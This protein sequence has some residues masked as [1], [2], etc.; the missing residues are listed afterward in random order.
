[1]DIFN[2]LIIALTT[3]DSFGLRGENVKV[4]GKDLKFTPE[5][6]N[7]RLLFNI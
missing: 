1:M 6:N 2:D 5:N 4:N 3:S 7:S